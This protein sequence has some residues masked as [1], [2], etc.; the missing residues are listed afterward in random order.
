MGPFLYWYDHMSMSW[1]D[2][3]SFKG[4]A[5][6]IEVDKHHSFPIHVH[7]P[8]STSKCSLVRLR[9]LHFWNFSGKGSMKFEMLVS[10]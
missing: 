4:F 7:S 3:D 10:K 6:M 8:Y 5:P 2:L 9:V 1:A